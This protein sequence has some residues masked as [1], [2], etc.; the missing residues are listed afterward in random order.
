M[1]KYGCNPPI[2]GKHT[3][4]DSVA[5]KRLFLLSGHKAFREAMACV[6]EQESDLEV[7]SQ[8]G[9]LA[10]MAEA[11]LDHNIDVALVDLSLSDGDAM[12]A[13]RELSTQHGDV[14]VLGLNSSGPS[15]SIVRAL[16]A[17]AAGVLAAPASLEEVVDAIRSSARG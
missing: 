2:F 11:N 13:L 6:L 17:G 16:G 10:D 4:E 14:A 12:A 5:A 1:G 8:A 7:V 15:S 3:M 9:S